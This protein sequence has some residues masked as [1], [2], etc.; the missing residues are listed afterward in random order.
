[1]NIKKFILPAF[2]GLWFAM[3]CV[4]Q[5]L[6]FNSC[7]AAF[8]NNKMLVDDYSPTGKCA[9]SASST[10]TLSV[11]TV[12]LSPGGVGVAVQKIKFKIA[13]RDHQSK[14]LTLFSSVTYTQVDLQ[15]VLARCRKGDSIVLIT[16]DDAYALPH[17]EILVM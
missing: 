13:L 2:L 16:T 7:S 8:V 11:S 17:N 1:M 15:K 4:A 10:G 12:D 14:T 9:L 5:K 6:P 3:P